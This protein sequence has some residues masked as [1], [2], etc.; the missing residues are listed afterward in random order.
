MEK[1][2]ESYNDC[3]VSISALMLVIYDLKIGKRSEISSDKCFKDEKC[4]YELHTLHL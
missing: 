3:C 4:N 1:K 2:S